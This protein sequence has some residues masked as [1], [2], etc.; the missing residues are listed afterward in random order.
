MLWATRLLSRGTS[1][2]VRWSVTGLYP[3]L[4]LSFP[5]FITS[6]W[7]LELEERTAC[8]EAC[9]GLVGDAES[10]ASRGV[11]ARVTEVKSRAAAATKA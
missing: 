6:R 10:Q 3:S 7:L 9:R 4:L 8:A 2:L 5:P 11:D 1:K